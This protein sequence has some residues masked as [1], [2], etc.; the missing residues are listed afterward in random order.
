[1]SDKISNGNIFR[2]SLSDEYGNLLFFQVTTTSSTIEDA[3]NIAQKFFQKN[4]GNL[5][6]N[7]EE[8]TTGFPIVKIF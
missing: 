2:F 5:A 4:F 7:I 3:V 1:M 8:N 6:S